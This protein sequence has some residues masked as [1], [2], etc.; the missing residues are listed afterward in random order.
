MKKILLCNILI[1]GLLSSCSL[2]STTYTKKPKQPAPLPTFE[3]QKDQK[4][5]KIEKKVIKPS[6]YIKIT[7]AKNKEYIKELLNKYYAKADIKL[8]DKKEGAQYKIE[9]I[10]QITNLDT[11]LVEIKQKWLIRSKNFNKELLQKNIFATT[12]NNQNYKQILQKY[13]ES[14]VLSSLKIIIKD[15]IKN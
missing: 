6:I 14:G 9:V 11:N 3:K 10:E 13:I 2:Y 8:E 5:Y 1:I 4:N 12:I 15:L 7:N